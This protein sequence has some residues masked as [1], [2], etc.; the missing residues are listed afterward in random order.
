M[1]AMDY[2]LTDPYLDPP[3]CDESAYSEKSVCLARTYWCY[4][5][6]MEDISASSSL[7]ALRDGVVTFASF[8]NLSKL[9]ADAWKL[10]MRILAEVPQSRLVLSCPFGSRRNQYRADLEAG[11]LNP[12]RLSFAPPGKPREY[13]ENYNQVD[14]GLDSFPFNGGT[15]TCDSL[16]MGVPSVTLR[17]STAVGRAGVSILTNAGLPELIADSP[18]EY[19]A[20]AKQLAGDLPR[21]AEIRRGLRDKMQASPLMDA[22]RYARDVEEAFRAMWRDWCGRKT[23]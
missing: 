21:L 1:T 18:D 4:Q 19:V 7:P 2:R 20:I 8:N 17:G 13:F 23:A 22:G 12:D 6:M 10:W 11:H 5:P 14:I 9:S 16:W 3:G 15:T